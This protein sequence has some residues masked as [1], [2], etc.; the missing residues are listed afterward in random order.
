[1]KQ[2]D[3]SEF[4]SEGDF[5]PSAMPLALSAWPNGALLK[6]LFFASTSAQ[7][8]PA[9]RAF[10]ISLCMARPGGSP[11]QQLHTFG[12]PYLANR[13]AL[14]Q[15]GL[16]YGYL[17]LKT[18]GSEKA[19][20]EHNDSFQYKCVTLFALMLHLP[21]L[22]WCCVNCMGLYVKLLLTYVF[23]MERHYFLHMVP[24][25]SQCTASFP[26]PDKSSQQM[27]Q[28]LGVC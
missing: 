21:A 13:S 7:F 1:M 6:G 24:T 3:G 18:G 10:K 22:T 16:R 28:S 15:S 25:K 9:A 17:L 20:K 4:D 26:L 23:H 12:L 14:S 8:N 5:Y 2:Q 11:S 27:T 19:L